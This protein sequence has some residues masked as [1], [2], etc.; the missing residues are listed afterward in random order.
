MPATFRISATS[1]ISSFLGCP[2]T[3]SSADMPARHSWGK[4]RLV[5]YNDF[6]QI[7]NHFVGQFQPFNMAV[8]KRS[9]E[10]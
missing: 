8:R 9:A 1:A 5:G 3:L 4:G 7:F 6:R 2:F 10:L